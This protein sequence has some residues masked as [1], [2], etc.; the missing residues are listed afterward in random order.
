VQT[1]LLIVAMQSYGF[2]AG[3]F[4]SYAECEVSRG[5]VVRAL[6]KTK[7]PFVAFCIPEDKR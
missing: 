2:T 5:V 6:G 4:A 1:F 7:W 3:P